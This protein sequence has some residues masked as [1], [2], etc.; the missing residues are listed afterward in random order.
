MISA[1]CKAHQMWSPSSLSS[2]SRLLLGLI[3]DEA[4]MLQQLWPESGHG[5]GPGSASELHPGAKSATAIGTLKIQANSN[6]FN[7]LLVVLALKQNEKSIPVNHKQIKCCFAVC[8]G[9]CY[10]KTL[11][12]YDFSMCCNLVFKQFYKI[13]LYRAGKIFSC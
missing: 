2:R 9:M 5:P 6:M 11:K 4:A 13:V 3:R 1:W 7:F 12:E 8:R 10:L